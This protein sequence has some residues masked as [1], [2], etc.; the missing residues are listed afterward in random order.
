MFRKLLPLLG[1]SWTNRVL[2]FLVLALA[3][4]AF[5]LLTDVPSLA[6]TGRSTQTLGT[7]HIRQQRLRQTTTH[8]GADPCDKSRQMKSI[9]TALKG[10]SYLY[11]CIG[12]FFVFLGYWIP[13]FYIVPFASV[14]L[15]ASS[16]YA[17]YLLSILNAGSFFGRI[18][19]AYLSQIVGTAS[20]LFVGAL[21]LGAIVFA[22][23]GIGNLPGI[24]VW[25]FL[26]G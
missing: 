16:S 24:S 25:C 10:R 3:L 6:S 2:A 14:S 21:S 9:L 15:G 20:V 23:L 13:L 12:V 17:S 1:W 11:L 18:L 19:P 26:V 22:W 5:S 7:Q 8:G 4:T